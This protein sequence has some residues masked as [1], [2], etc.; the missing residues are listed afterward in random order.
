MSPAEVHI[1]PSVGNFEKDDCLAP[2]AIIGFSL[3]FPQ[4]AV[5][6]ESFWKL[7][8]EKRCASSDFPASRMNIDA[9]YHPD[10]NRLD[11]LSVRGGHFI[12][13]DLGAFDAPFFSMTAAEAEAIDPQHRFTLETAYHALENAGIPIEQIAGS[14]TAVFTGCFTSDYDSF[15]LKDPEGPPK[16]TAVGTQP[17]MLANRISWFFNLVGPSANVDSACSSSM[18]ALDLA[19]KSLWSGDSTMVCSVF[20]V[21][22]QERGMGHLKSFY[23]RKKAF[24][25]TLTN[26]SPFAGSRRRQ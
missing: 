19:C 7:I 10:S 16:Y 21:F 18:V 13:G 24:L 8:M 11:S 15:M 26:N 4:D 20:F 25:V 23:G 5:S 2:L 14:K 9:H 12:Q 1:V 17:N 3:R 22:L 6:P